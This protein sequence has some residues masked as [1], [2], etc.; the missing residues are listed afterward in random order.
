[1][2]VKLQNQR[3]DLLTIIKDLKNAEEL[4]R[5]T[6]RL[7]EIDQFAADIRQQLKGCG[8]FYR[9]VLFNS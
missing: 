2:K 8:K 4:Q 3:T 6:R 7:D 9:F 1:V 5:I